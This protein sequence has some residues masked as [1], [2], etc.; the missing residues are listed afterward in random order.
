[1][2][3]K[4]QTVKDIF[5]ISNKALDIHPSGHTGAFFHLICR[6]AAAQDSGIVQL[7][8]IQSKAQCLTLTDEGVFGK[9]L[10]SV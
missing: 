5:A 10:E 4:K 8:D 2:M 3:I 1:M 9:G 6:K 7:K